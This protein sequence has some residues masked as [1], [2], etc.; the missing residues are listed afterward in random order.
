MSYKIF[1]SY[2]ASDGMY[3]ARLLYLFLKELGYEGI[4]L[5]HEQL[6][7]G[8]AFEEIR[9]VIRVECEDFLFVV[10]PDALRFKGK[11][12][13]LLEELEIAAERKKTDEKFNIVPIFT[14]GCKSFSHSG[15]PEKLSLLI[16]MQALEFYSNL[17]VEDFLKYVGVAME[18]RL[19]TKPKMYQSQMILGEY[20][21]PVADEDRLM[22]QSQGTEKM[23]QLLIEAIRSELGS[24]DKLSVLDVGCGSGSVTFSRFCAPC[25][26][27]V[28]GIDKNPFV[29]ERAKKKAAKKGVQDRIFFHQ[30]DLESPNLSERLAEIM[31]ERGVESFDLVFLSFVTHFLSEDAVVEILCSLQEVMRPGGYIMIKNSDDGLKI[32]DDDGTLDEIL[33]LTVQAPGVA[34]RHNGRKLYRFLAQSDFEHIHVIPIVQS[35]ESLHQRERKSLYEVSFSFRAT[36]FP[37]DPVKSERMSALLKRMDKNLKDKKWFCDVT[38]YAT[39]RKG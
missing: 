38:I 24:E 39:A 32:C 30:L 37:D 1:I 22:L 23:D 6:E 7:K 31:T 18:R 14:E 16:G 2:R 4:F 19:K 9:R 3:C 25:Y 8:D 28:V 10:T 34:D 11:D 17:P 13:V 12:D 5:D 33:A 29:I 27:T 21:D 35:T 36:L 15:L 26:R 20:Y